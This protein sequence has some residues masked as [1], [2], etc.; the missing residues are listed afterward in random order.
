MSNSG[1]INKRK[2]QRL[3]RYC[4]AA[5]CLPTIPTPYLDQT[6]VRRRLKS[7]RQRLSE[8]EPHLGKDEFGELMV[9]HLKRGTKVFLAAIPNDALPR[10]GE[11]L[12]VH[13]ARPPVLHSRREQIAVVSQ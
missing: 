3:G 7:R 4:D 5:D 13:P 9:Y 11:E 12:Q 6:S 2:S 10:T 1:R 8:G